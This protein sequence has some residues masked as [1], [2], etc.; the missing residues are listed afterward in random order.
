VRRDSGDGRVK[1]SPALCV[2]DRT[3]TSVQRDWTDAL[4]NIVAAKRFPFRPASEAAAQ[5]HDPSTQ[6][7]VERFAPRVMCDRL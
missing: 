3:V 4:M 6:S 5:G 2:T 7:Y 1:D